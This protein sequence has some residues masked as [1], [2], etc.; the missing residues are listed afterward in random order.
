MSATADDSII[1]PRIAKEMGVAYGIRTRV[2]AMEAR[3]H[4]RLERVD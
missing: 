4:D 3:H 2:M 1:P